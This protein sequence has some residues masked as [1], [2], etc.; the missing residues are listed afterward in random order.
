VV[1]QNALSAMSAL[2][3]QGHGL[4]M[5]PVSPEEKAEAAAFIE[6]EPK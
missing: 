4:H 5:E 1:A 2:I 3:F 6:G